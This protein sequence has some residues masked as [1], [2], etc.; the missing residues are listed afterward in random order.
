MC[1]NLDFGRNVQKILILVKLFEI[2][3]KLRYWSKFSRNRVFCRNFR[4][5]ANLVDFFSKNPHF[6]R[7]CRNISNLVEICKKKNLDFVDLGLNFRKSHFGRNLQQI[8]ILDEI[9]ENL[10]FGRNF[11]KILIFVKIYENLDIGR[12]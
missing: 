8:S 5:M 7:N 11:K 1:E 4:K 6:I 9:F 10:D 12:N 2:F 3:V